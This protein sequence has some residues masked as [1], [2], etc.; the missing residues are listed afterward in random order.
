[1]ELDD[2]DPYRVRAYLHAALQVRGRT[3]EELETPMKLQGIGP[4]IGT[5]I[6]EFLLKGSST[7]MENLCSRWPVEILS[8]MNVP[9]IGP[10]SAVALFNQGVTS[11]DELLVRAKAGQLS[12]KMAANVIAT[13][14]NMRR[15]PIEIALAVATKVKESLSFA[16]SERI[17]ICGSIRRHALTCKDIDIIAQV[18]QKN[19][20]LV[21]RAFEDLG[22]VLWSGPIKSSIMI[23]DAPQPIQCDLWLVQEWH[24]GS[25]LN[26]TTG[27]KVH[28]QRLRGMLKSRGMRLNEYGVYL[29]ADGVD[30][31]GRKVVYGPKEAMSDGETVATRIGGTNEE[32]VYRILGIPFVQPS[33][34]SE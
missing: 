25:A 27:N 1:M 30:L 2:A 26:Y 6:K 34:R 3:R 4:K 23:T 17:E 32:D 18:E 33:Q 5:T 11:F 31:D 19:A 12:S 29:P 24:W 8:L 21:K 10:K 16:S 13:E 7:K 9:G 22:Q 15:V 14:N 28:N 20:A